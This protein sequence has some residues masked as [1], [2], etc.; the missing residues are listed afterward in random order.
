MK[1]FVGSKIADEFKAGFYKLAGF[2]SIFNSTNKIVFFEID[3]LQGSKLC[4]RKRST[5]SINI[6]TIL[7]IY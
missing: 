2:F 1:T 4:F 3:K 5:H 7:K 6:S